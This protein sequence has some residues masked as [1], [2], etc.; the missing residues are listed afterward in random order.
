MLEVIGVGYP[1][2]GTTSLKLSLE[3]LGFGPTYH[4]FEVFERPH[5]AALWHDALDGRP[6]W[7]RIFADFRSSADAPACHFWAELISWFPESKCILTTRDSESWYESCR[8]TI[9]PAM[10]HPERA[11]DEA[12]R[13]VQHMARRL[14]LDVMFQ[15]AFDDMER[16]MELFEEHN[17][18]ILQ[19]IPSERLLVFDIA[20]GWG[21]LCDFLGVD[22]PET[23]FPRANTR[24]DFRSRFGVL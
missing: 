14:I 10:M 17:R 2:T 20:E 12:H 7:N 13:T 15:G 8:T 11:P 19:S 21:P 6:D 24:D 16:A 9:V 22:I 18:V 23:P 3:Q 1:R 4:M 5:H